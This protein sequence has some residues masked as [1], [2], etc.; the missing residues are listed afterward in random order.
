M[1]RGVTAALSADGPEGISIR[2]NSDSK[3]Y[4]GPSH[5]GLLNGVR[6]GVDGY[7]RIV[8]RDI[9]RFAASRQHGVSQDKTRHRHARN[10]PSS[11]RVEDSNLLVSRIS[12][13]QLAPSRRDRETGHRPFS[14]GKTKDM[15]KPVEAYDFDSTL[16]RVKKKNAIKN[17]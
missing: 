3:G 6:D 7:N 12:D 9:K 11:Q 5:K 14:D 2:R 4:I 16:A 10:Q 13:I 8:D 15:G 17:G 1:Q